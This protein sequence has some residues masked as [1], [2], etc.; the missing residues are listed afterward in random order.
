MSQPTTA[1]AQ[2]G[3]TAVA[4]ANDPTGLIMAAYAHGAKPEDL[5]E[6]YA[7]VRQMKA[8]AAQKEYAEALT[9]F[10]RECPG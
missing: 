7:L 10:Q 2:P 6:L 1:L 8:D 5:T 4:S 9:A 3:T